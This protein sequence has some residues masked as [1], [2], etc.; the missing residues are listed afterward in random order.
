MSCTPVPHV[1][2][3]ALPFP[4]GNSVNIPSFTGDLNFCCKFVTLPHV[5]LLPFPPL[6]LNNPAVIPAIQSAFDAL[7]AYFDGL[8]VECPRST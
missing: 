3:P 7:D 8:A 4:Y 6:F 5:P 1:A 2:P